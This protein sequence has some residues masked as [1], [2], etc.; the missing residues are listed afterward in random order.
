[1]IIK[2]SDWI[3]KENFTIF[4]DI[5]INILCTQTQCIHNEYFV[6]SM[7]S[8]IIINQISLWFCSSHIR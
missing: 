3:E 4:Y 8:I 7:S 2:K 1:M 6:S 5:Y